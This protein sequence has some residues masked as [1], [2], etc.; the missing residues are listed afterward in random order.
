MKTLKNLQIAFDNEKDTHL[1]DDMV[2]NNS[3]LAT[4]KNYD[5]EKNLYL[6]L[7]MLKMNRRIKSKLM[8]F[9]KPMKF[10]KEES[11]N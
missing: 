6:R 3:D 11:I 9:K 7:I 10:S 2:R 1:R 4:Q 8:K 5:K